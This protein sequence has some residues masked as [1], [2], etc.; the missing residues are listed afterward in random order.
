MS[1]IGRALLKPGFNQSIG[2]RVAARF[3]ER[4]IAGLNLQETRRLLKGFRIGNRMIDLVRG[5]RP[6]IFVAA[7]KIAALSRF[8]N[9]PCSAT[10]LRMA[11]RR[12]SNALRD[13]VGASSWRSCVSSRPLVT[14]FQARFKGIV[15]P[16][17]SHLVPA[18][19]SRSGTTSASALRCET[20]IIK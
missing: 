16:S 14:A 11:A 8:A 20:K 3:R 13:H 12:S 6:R 9:S 7:A 5:C 15:A 17:S 2:I 19:T 1:W 10:P 18:I 4:M